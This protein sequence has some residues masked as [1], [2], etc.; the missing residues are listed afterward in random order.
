[1]IEIKTTIRGG[2]PVVARATHYSAGRPM[3]ITGMGFGDAEPPEPEELEIELADPRRPEQA[4]RFRESL[5]TE[6]DMQRIESE[7]I[8]AIK[9]AEEDAS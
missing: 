1:M 8:A 7:L 2:L 5:A 4:D 6:S 9:S 3:R